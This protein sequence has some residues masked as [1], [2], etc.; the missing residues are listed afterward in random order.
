MHTSSLI[1]F[2]MNRQEFSDIIFGDK[3]EKRDKWFEI[4][5]DPV[6]VPKWNVS[7]DE[8]RNEAYKML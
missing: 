4:L 5:K 2:K 6:W 1:K 7:L 3:V 8:T